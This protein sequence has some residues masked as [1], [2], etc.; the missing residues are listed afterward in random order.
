M[1]DLHTVVCI[2]VGMDL[3]VGTCVDVCTDKCMCV[4]RCVCMCVHSAHSYAALRAGSLLCHTVVPHHAAC[5]GCWPPWPCPASRSSCK[6]LSTVFRVNVQDV[7]VQLQTKA[8]H[9]TV[10]GGGRGQKTG[11]VH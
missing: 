6:G 7:K 10:G 8:T 4:H 1:Q 5:R 2:G 9:G 3:C 11:A